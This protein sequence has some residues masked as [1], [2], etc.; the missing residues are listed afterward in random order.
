MKLIIALLFIFTSL[1]GQAETVWEYVDRKLEQK[2]FSRWSLS[3]WM[4]QKEKMGLQ[5]QWLAMNTLDNKILKEFYIDYSKS[6]FD[7]DTANNDNKASPGFTSEAAFYFGV[8]GLSARFEKYDEL[9]EQKEA[10][11]NLRLI[12]SSHQAT[13]LIATFGARQFYGNETEEFQQNFYGGDIALYLV[14]FFGFDGRYRY[15][16]NAQN[17]A[18]SH[19]MRSSRSQWGAFLDLAFIRLFV[20]QFEENI[21][22]KTLATSAIEKRQI[23]G[24]ATG[25]RFY[26]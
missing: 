17:Q 11:I 21:D 7:S 2:K 5:D 25:L 13:H 4:H 26:F 1:A 9:Y 18:E 10:A 12:G 23:K 16:N 6:T 24:T 8:L 15:Y 14:P 3:S 19:Q 22:Y 20:Y